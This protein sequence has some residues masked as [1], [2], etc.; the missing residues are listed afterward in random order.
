MKLRERLRIVVGLA[1]VLSVVVVAHVAAHPPFIAALDLPVWIDGP[2]RFAAPAS[3]G[4][5]YRRWD[6]SLRLI[7]PAPPLDVSGPGLLLPNWEVG[8]N[9]VVL[10]PNYEPGMATVQLLQVGVLAGA[11]P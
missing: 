6:D 2:D 4:I 1:L 9:A 5:T 10:I 7:A 11:T 3:N 8:R